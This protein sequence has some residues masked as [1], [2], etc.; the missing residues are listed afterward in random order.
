M[1]GSA[2]A[3]CLVMGLVIGA[4]PAREAQ[5]IAFPEPIDHLA[6]MRDLLALPRPK[7]CDAA[8]ADLT[9]LQMQVCAAHAFREAD[10]ALNR[11]YGLAVKEGSP[12][13]REKLRT[14]QRAWLAYRDAE[15]AWESGR[16]EGGTLA[17][18]TY[19]QCLVDLTRARV[20][21]IEAAMK[22]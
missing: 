4:L 7:S 18:V 14:A 22:P 19:G 5:A 2:R 21:A 20:E 10:A 8:R 13:H 16:Y 15:C 12:E 9:S 17:P 11:A 1:V 6:V 3:C